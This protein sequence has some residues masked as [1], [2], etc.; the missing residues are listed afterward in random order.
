MKQQETDWASR[1]R[2]LSLKHVCCLIRALE[3]GTIRRLY[4]YEGQ[5]RA[6]ITVPL[7]TISTATTSLLSRYGRYRLIE[8]CLIDCMCLID[9]SLSW[10]ITCLNVCGF[11]RAWRRLSVIF[12]KL[13]YEWWKTLWR[14]ACVLLPHMIILMQC[15]CLGFKVIVGDCCSWH[16]KRTMA[17][18]AKAGSLSSFILLKLPEF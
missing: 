18:S 1:M 15:V 4:I 3:E 7:R 5:E 14:S 13:S 12:Q 10:S 11:F 6:L 16:L 2:Y 8:L 17:R 9:W